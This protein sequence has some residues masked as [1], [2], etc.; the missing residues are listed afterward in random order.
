M[1][2][3]PFALLISLPCLV[4]Q[5]VTDGWCRLLR[6][7]NA[8]PA[9]RPKPLNASA[10]ASASFRNYTTKTQHLVSRVEFQPARKQQRLE[11]RRINL[12]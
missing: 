8:D 3:K 11:R 5:L 6:R 1:G 10:S 4:N 2:F 7:I 9:P 12:A